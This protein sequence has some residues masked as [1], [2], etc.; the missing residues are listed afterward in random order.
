MKKSINQ[1]QQF[2]MSYLAHLDSYDILNNVELTWLL[3]SNIKEE[4]MIA[5]LLLR[6]RNV[7]SWD[8]ALSLKKN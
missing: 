1:Y 2:D 3:S 4:R 8:E 7:S 6:D 5:I